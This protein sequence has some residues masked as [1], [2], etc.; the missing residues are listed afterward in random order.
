MDFKKDEQIFQQLF[1]SKFFFLKHELLGG[2][3]LKSENS[4]ALCTW[5]TC[6]LQAKQVVDNKN[7]KLIIF[8]KVEKR[9]RKKTLYIKT[10]K[11]GH[12]FLTKEVSI[13]LKYICPISVPASGWWRRRIASAGAVPLWNKIKSI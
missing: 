8:L 11:K 3:S 1:Y 6:I 13:P 4:G 9:M 10:V 7:D 5:L 12:I 2:I